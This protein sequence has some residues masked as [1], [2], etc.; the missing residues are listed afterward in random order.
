M[1]IEMKSRLEKLAWERS[2]PF[3]YL[4]Y[5]K[6]PSGRCLHCMSD[7]LMRITEDNGPE[8]GIEWVIE[9]LVK[10]NVESINLDEAFE[11]S[12]SRCYPETVT[13]G[14][15]TY[16]TVSAIKELDPISWDLAKSE[17]I[18]SEEQ[19]E[20]VVSFDNGCTYYWAHDVE[21]FLDNAEAGVE[22]GVA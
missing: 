13:I 1:N 14:W 21:S 11:E 7:D 18:D 15:I 16:D 10:A 2:I 19:D 20:Q 9:D 6:A 22:Q 17:W 3:C 5:S 8:Y 12:I 4:C